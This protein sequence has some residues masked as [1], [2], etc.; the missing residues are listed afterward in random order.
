MLDVVVV[1][2]DVD[3]AGGP[4]VVYARTY[5]ISKY[6]L[7]YFGLPGPTTLSLYCDL[8]VLSLGIRR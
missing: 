8:R 6:A 1:G 2:V 5:D 3:M 7:S 4:G